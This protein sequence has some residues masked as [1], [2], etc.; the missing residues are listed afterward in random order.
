MAIATLS[1]CY[2]NPMVFQG[3]VKIRK[4]QAVTLMMDATNMGAVQTIIAQY[5]QEVG[6]FFCGLLP[7]VSARY[8]TASLRRYSIRSPWL[9]RPGTKPS[10]SW[11]PSRRSPGCRSPACPP[12]PTTCPPCTCL[13]PCCS[14]PSVGSTWTP[15]QRRLKAPGTCRDSECISP[16]LFPLVT[17]KA[18]LLTLEV[19][20][21]SDLPEARCPL[22][23]TQDTM[24]QREAP[25]LD[26]VHLEL[27]FVRSQPASGWIIHQRRRV[28]TV[29]SINGPKKTFQ[30]VWRLCVLSYF[31]VSS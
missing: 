13:P 27:G 31:V 2:N 16:H 28:V 21:S 30:G 11:P 9:T 29:T 10:T 26:W 5:S 6:V 7:A 4:G 8:N 19:R 3:V 14:P 12:G 15:R 20:L 17:W 23:I 18:P 24:R 1:S 25:V 22:A